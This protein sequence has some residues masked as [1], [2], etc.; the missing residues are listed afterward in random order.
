[1]SFIKSLSFWYACSN[2]DCKAAGV[3]T[4]L[5]CS[6]AYLDGERFCSPECLRLGLDNHL[7]ELITRPM[8]ATVRRPHR[9][10]LGLT[11][12]SRGDINNETLRSALLQQK[13]EPTKR[14]G[15][16]LMEMSAVT[17]A[18]VTSAVASQWSVPVFK[19]NPERVPPAASLLPVYLME[20]YGMLP[21]H[22]NKEGK[23]LHVA[24][25]QNL[26]HTV[27][28]SVEKMLGVRTESC[29]ADESVVSRLIRK[30]GQD[31]RPAEYVLKSMTQRELV[32]MLAG[33]TLRL[34]AERLTATRCHDQI[35]ARAVSKGDSATHFLFAA[36]ET[37]ENSS[38]FETNSHSVR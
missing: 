28:Y 36:P 35:W 30:A 25:M 37:S 34:R 5:V 12:I 17:E 26:D 32:S 19:L 2:P 9:I 13:K 4:R 7:G 18:Q 3:T 27:L 38:S 6:G 31:E 16:I 14:I 21:V 20:R 15:Q 11:L 10:P 33:Y 1:M 8:R 23:R 29:I 24:F 22:Y